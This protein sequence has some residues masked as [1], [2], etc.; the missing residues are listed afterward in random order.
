MTKPLKTL[1]YKRSG[2]RVSIA[3]VRKSQEDAVDAKMYGYPTSRHAMPGMS[4][5]PLIAN[6]IKAMSLEQFAGY[7]GLYNFRKL[8]R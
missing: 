5:Q 2:E 7:S 8:E 3:R 1:W 4:A 6:A